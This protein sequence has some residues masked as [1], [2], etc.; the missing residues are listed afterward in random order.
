MADLLASDE[1]IEFLAAGDR[2]SAALEGIE[3][4]TDVLI[5]AGLA[6]GKLPFTGP[7]I[8][9]VNDGPVGETLLAKDVRAWLPSN[10]SQAELSAAVIAAAANLHVLTTDQMERR[11]RNSSFPITEE[12]PDALTRRELEVLR[13]MAN[14]SGNKEIADQLGISDNTVK[15]HIAQIMAKL[16]AHSRTEAVA[17]GMKRGLVPV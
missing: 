16:G 8:V 14:G 12:I 15:F 1:R 7:P 13:T 2:F 3:D 11:R 10:V 4:I 9:M 17:I 6:P 5:V